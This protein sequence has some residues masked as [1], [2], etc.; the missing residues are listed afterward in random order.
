MEQKKIVT[1]EGLLTNNKSLVE[2]I[3]FRLKSN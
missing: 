2:L 1:L 3:I